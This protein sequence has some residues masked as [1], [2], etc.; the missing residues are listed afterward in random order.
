MRKTYKD[1][2]GIILFLLPAAAMF[3]AFFIYP[4]GYVAVTSFLRWDGMTPPEFVGLNNYKLILTDEVFM[5]S[6]KNNLLWAMAGAFIQVP[7]AVIAALLL[8]RRPKGWKIFRTIYFFPNIISGVALAMMWA[9]IFNSE[10]GVL[11]GLLKLIGL[12]SLQRNWL[13][14]LQTAFPSLIIYWLFYI[15][16]YMIIVLAEISSIPESYYE[17]ASIDGASTFKQDL[18]ITLPLCKGSIATCMTLAM[19]YGLRQFEQVYMLTNGGPANK[20]SVMVL[21]L[22]KQIQNYRY[23]MANASGVVLIIIGAVVIITIKKLFSTE[24]YQM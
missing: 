17:A 1:Y 18:F 10:Y 2:I 11:N 24:K 8:A 9:A 21:Y 12:E 4:V 5:T 15:G 6:I 22:Y 23:G 3:A 20:T 7:L 14:E 19:V 13:G 16:Y